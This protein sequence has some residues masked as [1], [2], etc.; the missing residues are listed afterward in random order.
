MEKIGR[1]G[2]ITNS[3]LTTTPNLLLT[4]CTNYYE[5]VGLNGKTRIYKR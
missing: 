2:L 4:F 1:G 3:Q 5:G